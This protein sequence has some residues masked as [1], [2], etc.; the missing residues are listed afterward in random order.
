MRYLFQRILIICLLVGV[1]AGNVTHPM[2][3]GQFVHGLELC[4]ATRTPLMP[5]V[6]ACVDGVGV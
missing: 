5:P 4:I 3:K 1:G 2:V 6:V